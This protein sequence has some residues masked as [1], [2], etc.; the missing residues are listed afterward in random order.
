M[1]TG[2]RKRVWFT[3]LPALAITAVLMALQFQAEWS[4]AAGICAFLSFAAGVAWSSYSRHRDDS[5]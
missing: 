5:I 2:L 4:A 3:V 1:L